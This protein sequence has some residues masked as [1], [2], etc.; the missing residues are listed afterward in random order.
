M[1]AADRVRDG[2]SRNSRAQVNK[3]KPF[4]TPTYTLRDSF[5]LARHG[6]NFVLCLAW[7][8]TSFRIRLACA[9]CCKYNVR[10]A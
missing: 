8:F 1:A 7:V 3:R 5:L 9:Y 6:H 10:L 4:E 2:V